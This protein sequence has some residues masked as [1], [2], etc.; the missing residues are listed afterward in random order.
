M[1][2][3]ACFLIVIFLCA[4]TIFPISGKTQNEV[5]RYSILINL[6]EAKTW[7][8]DNELP[9]YSYHLRIGRLMM[10]KEFY[11]ENFSFQITEDYSSANMTLTLSCNETNILFSIISPYVIVNGIEKEIDCAPYFNHVG[12]WLLPFRF[13]FEALGGEVG[14]NAETREITVEVDL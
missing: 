1:R 2:K 12:S 5:D 10:P 11:K 14:W 13:I 8:N 7:I 9:R 6:N 4:I 3:L